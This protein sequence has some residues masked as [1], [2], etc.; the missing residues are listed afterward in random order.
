MT[1]APAQQHGALIER[2][3]SYLVLLRGPPAWCGAFVRPV[4]GAETSGLR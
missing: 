4:A 1:N 2:E 3:R